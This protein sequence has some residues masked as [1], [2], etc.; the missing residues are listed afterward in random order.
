VKQDWRKVC[1]QPRAPDRGD[2]SATL[3]VWDSPRR[4]YRRVARRFLSPS[5]IRPA[6]V[7]FRRPRAREAGIT[8]FLIKP[9]T[10]DELLA[11]VRHA[12]ARSRPRRTIPKY[13][14]VSRR[15]SRRIPMSSESVPRHNGALNERRLTLLH[16]TRSLDTVQG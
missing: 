2:P 5:Q 15:G 11:C 3:S 10:P 8:C 12:L 1:W 13:W 14:P 4:L 9:I 6:A 16:D 7:K